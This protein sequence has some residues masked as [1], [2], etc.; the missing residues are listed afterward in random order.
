MAFA[1]PLVITVNSI[2][3]SLNNIVRGNLQSQYR[4]ADGLYLFDIAHRLSRQAGSARVNSTVHFEA[5][6]PKEENP[7]DYHSLHGRFI[8][9]R[10]EALSLTLG[11]TDSEIDKFIG[12]LAAFL[13]TTANVTKLNSLQS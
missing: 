9:D 11:W 12:G 10:P 2:P 3:L 1:D 4:T 8:L 13:G 6:K 7:S 5:R